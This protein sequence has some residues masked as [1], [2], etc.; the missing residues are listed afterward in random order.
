MSV[1]RILS[2]WH[3]TRLTRLGFTVTDSAITGGSD[4]LLKKNVVGGKAKLLRLKKM[5]LRA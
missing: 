2:R 5:G 3:R 1:P 4:A